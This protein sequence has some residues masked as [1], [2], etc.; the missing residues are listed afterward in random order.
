MSQKKIKQLRKLAV[1]KRRDLRLL[2]NTNA[3]HAGSGYSVEMRDVL[4]RLVEDGWPI[5]ISAFYGVDGGPTDIEYPGNLNPRLKGLVIKHYP[6]MSE[7]WGSDGMFH[8]GKDWKTHAVFSM[9]DIWTLDPAFLSKIPV[10]IPWFPVDKEPLPIN[11]IQK[12]TFAYKI[13]CFSKFGHKL[14]LDAGFAAQLLLEGIDVDIFKPMDK[15]EMRKQLEIPQDR[16]LFFVVGAN[17][18]NPPRKGFQES[19]AAFK[20]FSDKHPEASILLTSQ[21]RAPT[22]FPIKEYAQ[23]LG[24]LPKIFFVD[25]Y[26]SIWTTSSNEMAQQYS[27][28]DATLHPSQTEGFGLCIVES[29]AC[30]RPV[31]IQN[32]QSMPELIIEGKTGF[33]A[34]TLYERFTSDLSFV[35][36]ADPQSVYECMEKT[37]ELVKKNPNKVTN[38]CRNWVVENFNVD[39]LVKNEWI[40]MLCDLQDELLPLTDSTK[41]GTVNSPKQ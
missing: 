41:V 37:Y 34:K 21:Q 15:F 28:C 27:A 24:I 2:F 38:D 8:H 16:F 12:L 35:N 6:R 20:M 32:C 39:T 22:G 30:G 1:K 33:G 29:Q 4:Y 31:I 25:D 36:V 13:M 26:K 23:Y 17:K 5:A 9:Q 11:V 18:E 19:L 3:P 7:A 40:P 14:L 10:W